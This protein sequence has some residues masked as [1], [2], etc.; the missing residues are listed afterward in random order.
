MQEV[1]SKSENF[2]HEKCVPDGYRKI[3][4]CVQI[5]DMEKYFKKVHQEEVTYTQKKFFW[6]LELF[7]DYLFSVH[8][9]LNFSS[10]IKLA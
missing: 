5:S 10:D 8:I 1:P 4:N 9:S 3:Q 6:D 2:L 7:Q